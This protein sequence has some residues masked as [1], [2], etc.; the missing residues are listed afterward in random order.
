[1][2]TRKN[3][4]LMGLAF[5]F[6]LPFKVSSAGTDVSSSITNPVWTPENSPYIISGTIE[7]TKG[8]LL[9]IEAGTEI[10]FNKGAK[11]LV[12]GELAVEGTID[13]PVIMTSNATSSAKGDWAGIE[14]SNTATDAIIKDGEY[15]SGSIIKNAIIKFGQGIK[16]TDASPYIVSNQVMYNTVGLE[17]N[18]G[19]SNIGDLVLDASSAKTNTTITLYAQNNTFTDNTTG[20]IINRGNSQN[21]LATPAGYSYLGSKKITSYLSGNS[22]NSNTIGLSILRGDNNIILNNTAKYN[23]GAGIQISSASQGNFIEKNNFNNNETGL[24]VNSS[25]NLILE[26]NIKNNFNVGLKIIAKPGVLKFNN[27]SNNQKVN[28]YNLV[29]NLNAT[30]NYWGSTNQDTIDSSFLRHDTSIASTSGA[31]MNYPIIFEPFLS[32]TFDLTQVIEPIFNNYSTSTLSASTMVSGIKPIGTDVYI[33]DSLIAANNSE[34]T[35]SY[36]ADLQLGDNSFTVYYQDKNNRRG[37]K[38]KINI[39]RENELAAPVIS[40]YAATTTSATI[41]LSGQKSAGSSVLINGNE[42][43]SADNYTTWKYTLPLAIGV[44]NLEIMAKNSSQ[45]SAV[46]TINITRIE[47]TDNDIINQE[48]RLSAKTDVK[49]AAKLSG[50]L[51]LQ[52]EDRGYIWYVSTVNNQRYFISQTSALSIFK[53]LSTGITE[54]NLNLVPTK[55]SGLKGNTAMRNRLKGKLLLRVEKAGQI[56]YV[57]L[58]GYRYDV[59]KENLMSLFRSLSLGVSN[60]NLRKIGVAEL[61]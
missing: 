55:E 35:W 19:E 6:L 20:L 7:V 31:L 1:M 51:L 53:S 57:D 17:I 49:L 59:T 39:R 38:I 12:N 11:I 3:A 10:R 22:F 40:A 33:N 52:V 45:Y 30:Q 29:Y 5:I 25:D 50:R 15:L 16:C 34:N 32:Q 48:K 58:N 4:Y 37:N 60:E 13:N 44:N 24:I 54:A 41:L 2:F 56:S 21:Y 42:V 9:K 47:V 28:L 43:S 36:N 46:I 23:S 18:G 14:F 26:N 8:A 27:I 61:K